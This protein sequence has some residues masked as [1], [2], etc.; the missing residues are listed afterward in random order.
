MDAAYFLLL[1][2][3]GSSRQWIRRLDLSL[4]WETC[5]GLGLAP[6]DVGTGGVKQRGERALSLCVS[7]IKLKQT[8]KQTKEPIKEIGAWH[9]GLMAKS[10]PCNQ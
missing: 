3:L 4:S 2:S 1:H 10:L 9:D 5:F 7:H 6:A 8:N